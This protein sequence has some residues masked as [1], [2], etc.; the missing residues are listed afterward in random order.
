MVK[1]AD[2]LISTVRFVEEAGL[3]EISHVKVH[4]DKGQKISKAEIWTKREVINKLNSGKTF[5]T[6][7][8]NT[9]EWS[10]VESVFKVWIVNDYFIKTRAD[11]TTK[12]NLD[13]LPT[14]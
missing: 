14:F 12:D 11:N 10:N 2:Y 6:I 13:N 8:M 4:V 1:W 9:N 3:K 5:R 7:V